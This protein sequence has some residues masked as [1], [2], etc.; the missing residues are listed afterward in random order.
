MTRKPFVAGKKLVNAAF[1]HHFAVGAFN[2]VNLETTQA[3][4]E[5]CERYR[6]PCLV[7]TSEKTIDYAGVPNLVAMTQNLAITVRVPVT[8]HL[9]HG[10]SVAQAKACIDAGYSSVMIDTSLENYTQNVKHTRQVVAYARPRGVSVEAEIGVLS[11][12]TDTLT[13]PDMAAEFAAETGVDYLA[14]AIGTKHGAFK[15]KRKEKIDL[16][17]LKQIH[18]VLPLPL[19]LHGASSVNP[20]TIKLANKYGARLKGM[21]GIPEDSI[22]KAIRLGI[23]KI[24]IDTDLRLAFTTGLRQ[25]LAENPTE[26]GTR[27]AL[28]AAKLAVCGEIAH[29]IKLFGM[30]NKAKLV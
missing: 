19:V 26:F 18:D 20:K 2:T 24:N 7:Q 29:K 8:L 14:V 25:F 13:D 30:K 6:A 4:I 28:S 16:K 21:H 15:L 1:D 9:D 5:T 11:R 3:I 10:H 27:E 22:K 17:R 12:N 23:T